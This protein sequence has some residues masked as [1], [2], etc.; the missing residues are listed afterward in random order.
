MLTIVGLA[1]FANLISSLVIKGRGLITW[2]LGQRNRLTRGVPGVF[3]GHRDGGRG[4][5]QG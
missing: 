1:D 3:S 4:V 2:A 5:R